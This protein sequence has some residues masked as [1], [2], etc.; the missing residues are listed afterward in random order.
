MLCMLIPVLS[1]WEQVGEGTTFFVRLP[2]FVTLESLQ[3]LPQALRA[4]FAGREALSEVRE[5]LARQP[6]RDV[7]RLYPFPIVAMEKL[8][9]EKWFHW[10]PAVS[11]HPT[12]GNIIENEIKFR[13]GFSGWG[14]LFTN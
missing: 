13:E 3:P 1:H 10:V 11:C 5:Y 8:R 9:S 7:Q 6:S 14:I 2:G 4:K 12:S